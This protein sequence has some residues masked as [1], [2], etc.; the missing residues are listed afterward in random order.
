MKTFEEWSQHYSYDP[1]SEEAK[2]DYRHYQEQLAFFQTHL[3]DK[4]LPKKN[5]NQ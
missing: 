4:N 2:A 1:E 3:D 5:I